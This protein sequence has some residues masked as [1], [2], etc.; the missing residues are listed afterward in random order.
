MPAPRDLESEEDR[1][2][3]EN[4][5]VI[6]QE[7][8]K[9]ARFTVTPKFYPYD[10]VYLDKKGSVQALAEIKC[11]NIKSTQYKTTK[12]DLNK[13]KE[14]QVMA[15]AVAPRPVYLVIKWTDRIGYINMDT[16]T[17]TDLTLM[18]R[19][20]VRWEGDKQIAAEIAIEDFTFIE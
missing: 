8:L 5:A 7:H 16:A 15:K 18:L 13:F 14:L 17:L 1:E 19:K 12:I 11:R 6:V 3:E 9:L 2:N 10:I 20:S 4:V